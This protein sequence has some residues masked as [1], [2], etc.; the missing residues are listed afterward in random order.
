MAFRENRMALLKRIFFH[1][2]G[3]LVALFFCGAE[4]TPPPAV[5][6]S[7]AVYAAFT[8]N[9]ARFITWPESAFAAKGAPFVIGTFPRDPI[10][11]QLDAAVRGESVDGHPM[12]TMRLHSPDDLAK[13]HVVF[14][15]KNLVRAG[16]LARVANRPVLAVSDADDF[17]EI[18]GHVRFVPQPSR[19]RLRIA[20]E[21]LKASGLEARAQLLR[22][23]AAP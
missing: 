13:C 12:Q 16:L 1:V 20:V 10:N 8:V 3:A 15:S 2:A 6:N 17:L 21:N 7:E 11:A 9:L 14:I 19:T 23:A 18:G 4:S 22:L 5:A